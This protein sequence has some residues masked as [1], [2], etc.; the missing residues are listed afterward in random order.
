MQGSPESGQLSRHPG[1][2]FQPLTGDHATGSASSPPRAFGP[3]RESFPRTHLP[4]TDTW[5]VRGPRVSLPLRPLA[6][7]GPGGGTTSLPS[8]SPPH[9]GGAVTWKCPSGQGRRQGRRAGASHSGGCLRAATRVLLPPRSPQTPADVSG[10]RA[11]HAE[12]A[13]HHCGL[14]SAGP[15]S[16]RSHGHV[17]TGFLLTNGRQILHAVRVRV[18][19]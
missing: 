12:I 2:G 14:C 15:F 19:V 7:Q 16:K 18:C 9:K 4:Q 17:V 8:L 5:T 1:P 11:A 10:P 6:H 13:G 3:V